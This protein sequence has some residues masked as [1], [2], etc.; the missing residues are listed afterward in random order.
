[1][2]EISLEKSFAESNLQ[3]QKLHAY[4]SHFKCDWVQEVYNQ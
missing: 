3:K 2:F 1:M 4:K